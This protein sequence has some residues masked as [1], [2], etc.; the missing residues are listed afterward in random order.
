MDFS[1]GMLFTGL[2]VFATAGLTILVNKQRP[3]DP[4][5]P[6]LFFVYLCA[7]LWSVGELISVFIVAD[8]SAYWFWTVVKFTGIVFFAPSWWLFTIN[9]NSYEHVELPKFVMSTRFVPVAVSIVAFSML[10]TNPMHHQFIV[11]AKGHSNEFKFGWFLHAANAYSMIGTSALVFFRLYWKKKQLKLRNQLGVMVF[12]SMVPMFVSVPY[13]LRIVDPGF[14]PTV[15]A[16]VFSCVLF[17]WGIYHDRLFLLNPVSLQHLMKLESDG[18]LI[19][20]KRW[21]IAFAN[22]SSRKFLSQ[23]DDFYDQSIF[24]Q[25]ENQLGRGDT[26]EQMNAAEIEELLTAPNEFNPSQVFKTNLDA[27]AWVTLELIHVPGRTNSTSAI[28]IRI[29]DVTALEN[30]KQEMEAQS[31]ILV[32]VLSAS[33]QGILVIDSNGNMIYHNQSFQDIWN[34]PEEIIKS[35]NGQKAMEHA[36]RLLKSPEQFTQITPD[37]TATNGESSYDVDEFKDGRFVERIAQPLNI[38]GVRAGRIWRYQDIT[39]KLR[40]EDQERKQALIFSNIN[41]GVALLDLDDNIVD[42]NKAAEKLTGYTREEVIN[43]PPHFLVH[44]KN[45]RGFIRSV[46]DAMEEKGE[47]EGESINV[48]KD[49]SRILCFSRI[50]IVYDHEQKRKGV[51]IVS[52]DITAEKE[53][54]EKIQASEKRLEEANQMLKLV[55]DSIPVRVFWKDLNGTYLGCNQLFSQDAGIANPE[56]LIGLN[57]FDMSWKDQAEAYRKDDKFV[58]DT[59]ETRLNFEEPQTTPEGKTIWLRTS[60]VPLY[61]LTGTVIGMMGAYEEITESRSIREKLEES[62]LKTKV[63]NE[64]LKISLERTNELKIIAE[65]ANEAKSAFLANM[66]HEIRTPMNGIIG[67][68]SLLLNTSLTSEQDQYLSTLK[69][70]A[71]SLLDLLNDI[72]DYS[73]ISAGRMNLETIG[74]SFQRILEDVLDIMSYPSDVSHVSLTGFRVNAVPARMMGDPLRIRQILLNLVSNAI[75]FSPDGEVV[76]SAS[77]E[78]SASILNI[79]VRDT[80]I[81]IKPEN[82]RTLYD[83]FTQADSS[84]TRK[85]GGTGL[86]LTITHSLI[87]MMNG[88]LDV[89]S[90][91]NEGS[92][93]TVRL[94]LRSIAEQTKPESGSLKGKHVVVCLGSETFEEAIRTNLAR[95]ECTFDVINSTNEKK[96]SDTF[97][98]NES[99]MIVDRNTISHVPLNTNNV[100]LV[101]LKDVEQVPMRS[102]SFPLNLPLRESSLLSAI[103]LAYGVSNDE[104]APDP[105]EAPLKDSEYNILVAE[106]N[107]INSKVVKKILE[108]AHFTCVCKPNGLEAVQELQENPYDLILMD[109]QMPEMDGYEATRTIRELDDKELSRTPI[110]ALTAHSMEGD[111]EKCL[112]S[113]MDDYVT[114]PVDPSWLLET[115][116]KHMALNEK[117]QSST[118]TT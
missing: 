70:S 77:Y 103:E 25:L 99:I 60:K 118:S 59:K 89:Q 34:L 54:A 68:A 14:D 58:I 8:P 116:R 10:L 43:Q 109:C 83:S 92:T 79:E 114:K 19:L 47:W 74:F 33:T 27:P 6:S 24:V 69:T 17:A 86:G 9:F 81:G 113:G 112:D 3:P 101:S 63:V 11:A 76:V 100:V 4:L 61:D 12:A 18:V 98:T 93:F 45:G 16:F 110:I 72:L 84:T 52:R 38:N 90:K 42:W 44:D 5:W 106:D 107:V 31:A 28:G 20:D 96:D 91:Y 88:T 78:E 108:N 46:R 48:R 82:L 15:S 7:F 97:L 21:N 41:D 37:A 87:E 30:F 13:V 53:A 1:W 73:K 56:S 67:M 102:G 94:P 23:P 95:W 55:L 32:G 111:R 39:K 117:T 35:G 75:K 80:G 115:I 62:Q 85:F 105:P 51:M 50:T 71:N 26:A 49:L 2:A 65:N 40:E 36:Q 57:D 66:S 22:D 104:A 64:E 29:Q